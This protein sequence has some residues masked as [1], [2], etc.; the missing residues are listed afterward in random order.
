[1][2]D[3]DDG[4]PTDSRSGNRRPPLTRSHVCQWIRRDQRRGRRDSRDAKDDVSHGLRNLAL[5]S[6]AD[7]A[8]GRSEGARTRCAHHEVH[9]LV[10]LERGGCG[11][12]RDRSDA[13]P[14]WPEE[15]PSR[16]PH[17]VLHRV[18]GELSG[19]ERPAS[20]LAP[21]PNTHPGAA[22]QRG[23]QYHYRREASEGTT[24]HLMRPVRLAISPIVESLKEV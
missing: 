1:M 7:H 23:G 8:I 11:G 21:P 6:L 10:Y 14:Q 15:I 22:S 4:D 19:T 12:S 17:H 3:A 24:G 5:D 9:P 13:H 18:A 16:R 20:W 2:G